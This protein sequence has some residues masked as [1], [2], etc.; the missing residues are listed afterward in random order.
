MSPRAPRISLVSAVYGV[1]A[2]LPEFLDSLAA[3]EG[4]LEDTE[5]VFVVDGSPDDSA[6][7][8]R[9]WI[10]A[11]GHDANLI[12]Q[13]NAGP[14]AARNAGIAASTGTWI[15]FPDPD[16]VL[17]HGYLEAFRRFIAD[18][19]A[20]GIDFVAARAMRFSE[21]V[22]FARDDHALGYRFR[23]GTRIAAPAEDPKVIH[24][25][26]SSAFV[27]RDALQAYAP[28]G[29]D[30]TVRPTFEDGHLIA[31]LWLRSGT[32]PIGLLADAIYYYRQRSDGTSLV[33]SSV[34][35]HARYLELPRRG[36]LSLLEEAA[37]GTGVPRWL[38]YLVLY[39]LQW[40]FREDDGMASLTSGLDPEVKSAY[41]DAV[42]AILQHID[43]EVILQFNPTWIPQPIRLAWFV[44]KTGRLPDELDVQV[45]RLDAR[46]QLV[47]LRW[48]QADRAVDERLQLDGRDAVPVHAKTRAVEYFG[49]EMLFE[50]I[51]WVSALHDIRLLTRGG[52]RLE[53]VRF[54]TGDLPYY[55]ATV[56]RV[57]RGRTS[58]LPRGHVEAAAAA[59]AP[60][61][62]IVPWSK[63]FRRARLA[64]RWRYLVTRDRFRRAREA[65]HERRD[66]RAVDRAM[67]RESVRRRFAGAWVLMDRD[68]FA[69][70]NA[71]ALYRYLQAEQPHVNAW[72][73]VRRDSPDYRRLR[74]EG[75]R[76]AAF[77][78]RR[79]RVLMRF[80]ANVI[81]SQAN[82]YVTAP[83]GHR[84]AGL[85]DW[86]FTFLQ[87]GVTKDD[88][89][90]WLNPKQID[91]ILACTRPEYDAFV[92][93]GS[94]YVFTTREV[95]LTGFPR[96]DELR[97]VADHV[98]EQERDVILLVPTW[99]N[100]L[101][102]RE[103]GIG[104]AR[105]IVDDFWESSYITNWTALA[106]DPRLARL[107]ERTGSRIV[108]APHPN[109]QAH[110]RPEH[111]PAHVEYFSYA[112]A[113]I[114]SMIVRARIAV[115]DYSSLG[116]EAALVGVPLVYFQ[117]DREEFFTG[118][119]AYRPGY[120][121][122]ER[123]GYGPM[124]EDLDS[125]VA[126][127]DRLLGDAEF[128]RR[129]LERVES[130][131]RYRDTRNSERA[132]RAIA[133]LD[134][135]WYDRDPGLFDGS[136]VEYEAVGESGATEEASSTRIEEPTAPDEPASAGSGIPEPAAAESADSEMAPA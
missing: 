80:A 95:A 85:G 111:L 52:T 133:S 109:L 9:R 116:T 131:F 47:Q 27:R 30:A 51:L 22:E 101:L 17:A 39:D 44:M 98:P 114:K 122:A 35:D 32:P 87:H 10:E 48:F 136:T 66:R 76:L 12:V 117:F 55:E 2:Y 129:Y 86:K 119:H 18:G 83:H 71:E 127:I 113:D 68:D 84:E 106:A 58:G 53:R 108:F 46:E 34:K 54:G 107:A 15:G 5:L 43:E 75:F 41:L 61:P 91:L 134:R 23:R 63:P 96:H 88:L 100:Y 120:F 90:R 21:S 37:A 60:R 77:G 64:V 11:T 115:T 28:E 81:S 50:R 40:P 125:A 19:S 73:V 24:L 7:V 82:A 105:E 132:Y 123:D 62:E 79:H 70:D 135:P 36:Y 57:W 29:F 89:S 69:R 128:S 4:G 49:R 8:I 112:D 6:G 103:T 124:V 65:D 26:I 14:G 13:D 38:Q 104:S 45:T 25:Q 1:E 78:S 74:R 93:D 33:Q 97:S 67:G 16:D 3:Q 72:F 56:N 126:A 31:K 110:L 42:E 130:D 59:I 94:Q 20:A 102:K 121:R 92:A 118:A 99:R